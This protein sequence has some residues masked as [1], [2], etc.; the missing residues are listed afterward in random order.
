M[1]TSP[2]M[3]GVFALFAATSPDPVQRR[4]ADGCCDRIAQHRSHSYREAVTD[5][6]PGS[7]SAPWV[8]RPTHRSYRE[9]VAQV[10]RTLTGY[11]SRDA[12][13]TQGALRDPGLCCGTAS[14]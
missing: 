12:L 6:S 4:F 8:T 13:G 9:A 11:G 3:D 14:R 5:H 1:K 10:C 2:N 7:R